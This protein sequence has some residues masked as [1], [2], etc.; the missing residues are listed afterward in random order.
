MIRRVAASDHRALVLESV[1]TAPGRA[2]LLDVQRDCVEEGFSPKMVASMLDQLCREGLVQR[3]EDEAV[4]QPGT[5][6]GHYL[7]VAGLAYLQGAR[8]DRALPPE[9]V[10][11]PGA[12][13]WRLPVG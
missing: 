10:P 13:K 5:Q 1:A 12:R 6:R 4:H 11:R 7:T 8:F 3:R 2:T 9:G